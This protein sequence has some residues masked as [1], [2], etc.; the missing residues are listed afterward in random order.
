MARLVRRGVLTAH[1]TVRLTEP[2]ELPEG[3][4]VDVVIDTR[5]ERGSLHLML[6]TLRTIH[7]DLDAAGHCPPTDEEVLARI[8]A[9]RRAWDKENLEE[10]A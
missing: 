2:V 4:E 3:T 8:E 10:G 7:A 6:E 9:E 1:D 5:L